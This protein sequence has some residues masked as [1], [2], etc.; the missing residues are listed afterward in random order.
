VRFPGQY[1]DQE[2]G[3]HY[4]YFRYYDPGT[5]RYLTSD[6]TGLGANT[7]NTYAYVD[8]NPINWFD[9]NGLAKQNPNT[10]NKKCDA[11]EWDVCKARCG[12]K[13]VLSCGVQITK[14]IRRIIDNNGVPIQRIHFDRIIN[15]ECGDDDPAT[16][17]CGENCQKSWVMTFVA[18]VGLVWAYVCTSFAF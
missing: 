11:S 14:K 3:L 9:P 8:N 2:T 7:L 13:G 1:Y 6:P 15:C 12:N 18:G 16:A 17:S 10:T 4:N 5:G